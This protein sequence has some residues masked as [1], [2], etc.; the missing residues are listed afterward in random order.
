M[1]ELFD[2]YVVV[3]WSAAARPTT[4]TDSIWIAV[5]DDRAGARIRLSNPSTRRRAEQ[6]LATLGGPSRR[7]LVTFDA[8]LGYP[9]GTSA[10]FGLAGDRPWW[11]MWSHLAAH[12]SDAETN[13]NDRFA[14]AAALNR[15]RPGTD[16]PFWGC[17]AAT[18]LDGLRA[19]RPASSPVPELRLVEARLRAAGR[20]PAS[21]WQLLGAGSVGSQTLTLLPVLH[22]LVGA[23]SVEVWP[24]TTGAAAPSAGRGTVVV[25]ETWPT[26]FDPDLSSH[27]VRDAAQVLGVVRR[28]RDAD[29][30]GE[31]AGWFVPTLDRAQTRAVESE[32]GW[33][34]TPVPLVR[35]GPA[36]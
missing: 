14:V 18:P 34:L 9:V 35:T 23:G 12:L 22:R 7:T 26:A 4:G 29:R 28:L 21:V 13:V 27:T 8:S 30:T 19:R 24:F 36:G 32:E 20:R 15:R 16:A 10:W 17:P 11:A 3:D 33:A 31:L 6:E 25:A 2:R 5:L 1:G